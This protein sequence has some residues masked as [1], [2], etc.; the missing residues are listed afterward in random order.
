MLVATDVTTGGEIARAGAAALAFAAIAWALFAGG[1]QM[2]PAFYERR[3]IRLSWLVAVG[4]MGI[5]GAGAVVVGLV[6]A[7]AGI[8]FEATS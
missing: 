5:A 1:R 7:V 2:A 4:V 6:C 8:N 3:A